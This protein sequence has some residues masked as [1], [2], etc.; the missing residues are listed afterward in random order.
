[1]KERHNRFIGI[2]RIDTGRC[3]YSSKLLGTRSVFDSQFDGCRADAI[4]LHQLDL[5]GRWWAAPAIGLITTE[6]LSVLPSSVL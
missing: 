4:R 1:M 6:R 2:D 5:Y 3:C